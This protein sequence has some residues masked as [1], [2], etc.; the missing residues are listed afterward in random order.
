MKSI[1]KI[2]SLLLVLCMIV[3]VLAVGIVPAAAAP[4]DHA[5]TGT[6]N[7][8]A[9]DTVQG[10]NILHCFNWSYANIQANLADIAAAG[11]TAVQTSPVQ[12][13]VDYN[14]GWTNASEQWWKLYQP[15]D[16]AIAGQ[17]QSWLGSASDLSSLC[18]AA[19]EY[20]IKVIVDI[21]SNHLANDGTASGLY[22]HLN[23]GAAADMKNP[24]YF[25]EDSIA[26]NG[27]NDNS[28][29]TITQYNL[30]MPELKTQSGYVQTKAL[31]LLKACIDCGVDGFRFDTAKHIELPDES[32]DENGTFGGDYWPT[33]VNG[34]KLYAQEKGVDVPFIYGEILNSAGT[35]ISNYTTYMAV[36]DN[37]TGDRALDKAYWTA[38]SELADGTYR[39]GASA[40]NSVLW[41]ESHDTYMGS[42]GSAYFSNTSGVSDDVIVN[43][44]AIVGARAD[45]TGLFFARPN[46][47]MGAASSDT[48]W[49]STEV[50]E[51]NKFKNHFD[52]TS[53]TLASSGNT[54]YIVRGSKGVVISKLD[55]GG[56][57]SLPAQGMKS[58]TY[59]DQVSNTTF[60]VANGTISGTVG[61]SGVA[62]V[63][64]PADDAF[65]YITGTLYL[66][67]DSEWATNT[68]RYAMY[69]FNSSTNA[70]VD[71][72]YNSQYDCYQAAV[73][74]GN[75]TNV[76]F[77]GMNNNAENSWN[78]KVRQTADLFP[79]DGTDC[80]NVSSSRWTDHAVVCE[81]TYGQPT[82][83]WAADHSSAT[84]TF[85]C[86][87]C[88]DVQTVTD[89]S[90]TSS[91]NGD[92]TTYTA[93]VT[94]DGSSYTTSKTV[95]SGSG[96]GDDDTYTIYAIDDANWNTTPMKVY[97]WGSSGTNPEWS[98]PI[99]M[100]SFSGTKVYTYDIPTDVGG[101]I[102]RDSTGNKQ[103]ENIES[104]FADGAVWTITG[105]SNNYSV[106]S[107]PD[108]YLVGNMN[109]W[110]ERA[111][112]KFTLSE[113]DSGALEYKL[114]GVELAE[115]AEFK[116]KSGTNWYPGGDNCTVSTAGTYDIYFRPNGDGN[117][118]WLPDS[119]NKYFYLAEQ[120]VTPDRTITWVNED[121]TVL[122]TGTVPDGA[123][124]VYRGETP[125]KPS[126]AQY[127]YTF[128][129]WSPAVEAVSADTTYTAQFTET[130]RT[131]TVTWKN[132]NGTV[133]ETDTGVAY[134]SHPSYDSDPP[135]KDGETFVG[136]APQITNDTVITGD[137]TYTA[138]F[139][140]AQTYTITWNN[141]NG[142]SLGTSTCT[143][144]EI[145]VYAGE[146]PTK[147]ADAQY[148][149]IFSGWSPYVSYAYEN[150]T[151]TAQ[152]TETVNE[153]T[154][155][156]V[157]GNGNTLGTDT[158]AYGETPVYDAETHGTP[159]K[160]S[161]LAKS[162]TFNNSWSPA[163]TSVTGNA[164]Y[165]AQFSEADID[166]IDISAINFIG[167]ENVYVYY[168]LGDSNNT[169]P[170][171]A[172]TADADG[173]VYTASIPATAE[174]IIFSNGDTSNNSANLK[175]TNNVTTGITDGARWAIY[176]TISNSNLVNC[177]K[178]PTYKLVG[179]MNEWTSD[180]APVFQP[181]NQE[182]GL[183]QYK[184]SGVALTATDGFK[185]FSDDG[186]G[187]Q[188]FPSGSNNDAS[189]SA[190]G[191][192]DIYF[193][194]NGDGTSDWHQNVLYAANVTAYTITWKLDENTT[195]D[196]TTVAHGE[197]PTHADP[198]KTADA[199]Y[200][201]TFSGWSPEVVAAT[202]NATYTAQFTVTHFHSMTAHAA[203]DA[204]CTEAGNSAYWSCDTCG[205]YFS[206]AEGENEIAE[207]NWVIAA[208]GHNLTAHPATAATRTT[209]GNTAYWSCDRCGKYFSDEDGENEIAADS[210]IIPADTS[211]S[212]FE[213]HS[214]TLHGDIGVIFFLNVTAAEVESG[215]TVNFEWNG[216][217]SSDTLTLENYK[218]I[219]G[220][221]MYKA[222]C[223]VSAPEMT[224]EITAA[225][226]VGGTTY[227]DT[228]SVK[229]Y[230]NVILSDDYQT[231]F[232]AIEG[233]TAE[234]YNKLATLVKTMLNYGAATQE[235]FKDAHPNNSETHSDE[236]LANAGVNYDL[237]PLIDTEI[238]SIDAEKPNKEEINAKL[239][240][241]GLT[242]YGYT[243]LLHSKT[244]LRFYFL[245]DDP[246]VDISSVNLTLNGNALQ[247]DADYPDYFAYVEVSDIPAYELNQ[248]YDLKLNGATIGSY[249]AL[250]YVKDVLTGGDSDETLINT[251]TA[252]YRYHEAA[253]DYFPESEG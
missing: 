3:S 111:D 240:G 242:Y 41:A 147:A 17:N 127:S 123:T 148:T 79:D 85:T 57:V 59:T 94:F 159:T 249:S 35:A 144:G 83:S 95:G 221:K 69:V 31:D 236:N 93:T 60:T 243:M 36:T 165:T 105:S 169:W 73:P 209:A 27:T 244:K 102:F 25:R 137:T 98:S 13:P 140:S 71:M 101:I 178:V 47:T 28:R 136:W 143:Y 43:T 34:A 116:A 164:T 81:H 48:T 5:P 226:I 190:D 168:W 12:P 227:T 121:G 70:W 76:I 228:Y 163:I 224:D 29:F 160:A 68:S 223:Y 74:S 128:S 80:Y 110:T 120:V 149:Y 234:D 248:K 202:T 188:W 122:A 112:Y 155:T 212:P 16:L 82:W 180:D 114:S 151:Y 49:K 26:E 207:N 30:G 11:Y 200:T 167:W 19:D 251:V 210:W 117:S 45:S 109:E 38:A 201:Y 213:K 187:G 181:V 152:F 205:K 231:K 53:E 106:A 235:Q 132:Y 46:A 87:T 171:V 108:Y 88:G 179:T 20:G 58:G 15:L 233:K 9:Q 197:V 78:N 192:Y 245:K 216:K 40:A 66:K 145:P 14:A 115:G 97:W 247:N 50:A 158:V 21:V 198:T 2:T 195:I 54:A 133:I 86:S 64:D 191:T 118:D 100:T 189:V 220:V 4:A 129:G 153:Y 214:L 241:T 173:L 193:R 238:N 203:V 89:S 211:I 104:G 222:I 217:T 130:T 157:D 182:N 252:M 37:E 232:L 194:P 170:G 196:T 99:A 92:Y 206:D 22:E 18:T 131:Y 56:A 161:T 229:T 156:W 237:T 96:S 23:S 134:G 75:W 44:W 62:V 185:A 219:D 139:T 84:A 65:D 225:V 218:M 246:S 253:V 142:T 55:G 91:V 103:T 125:T 138:R 183:E 39:K 166:T 52:G 10:S 250:T 141:Y 162:Y 51:V 63:Y 186:T 8:F 1:R 150:K 33:V 135:T 119:N 215:I 107:A 146:T 184:V 7:N 204:T 90:P 172:M 24:E 239:A 199:Q 154:V 208:T 177:H 230:A 6:V 175:Q 72:T 176:R 42:A 126:T 174:G 61:S 77:C 67:P 124:P 32:D 113:S